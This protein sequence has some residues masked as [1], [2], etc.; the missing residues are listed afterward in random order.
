M[1]NVNTSSPELSD[2]PI[3]LNKNKNSEEEDEDQ[4]DSIPTST[5]K[6]KP[7]LSRQA[8]LLAG[9]ELEDKRKLQSKSR[10]LKPAPGSSATINESCPDSTENE[11]VEREKNETGEQDKMDE[12]KKQETSEKGIKSR[13]KSFLGSSSFGKRKKSSGQGFT[14]YKENTKQS[15]END[16]GSDNSSA[17]DSE[18]MLV[19]KSPKISRAEQLKQRTKSFT[20]KLL[21][22]KPNFRAK[23]VEE[24]SKKDELELETSHKATSLTSVANTPDVSPVRSPMKM[25]KKSGKQH[26]LTPE[27]TV[28]DQEE[29]GSSFES[30]NIFGIHIHNTDRKLKCSKLVVHPVIKVHVIDSL[31]GKYLRKLHPD[32]NVVS[33]YE[34]KCDQD[35]IDYIM[36]IM[37]QPCDLLKHV[38]YQRS[39]T[40][41]E[42]LLYNEEFDYFLNN[43]IILFFEVRKNPF[44]S[45]F[46]LYLNF[47]LRFKFLNKCCQFHF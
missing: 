18:K 40:W 26:F 41:E 16:D 25:K 23:S 1:A 14:D 11:S 4:E 24:S 15:T 21:V 34:N 19:N 7:R 38:R 8:A 35:G 12:Q 45:Y 39:P 17:I 36:P 31:T 37:T 46:H 43:K 20:S 32:R 47:E 33:Y 42:L 2:S 30:C 3:N 5:P 6:P 22:P 28:S 13:V 27:V 44:H 9:H 29:S 10:G